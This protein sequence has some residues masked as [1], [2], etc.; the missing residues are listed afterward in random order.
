LDF[1][2][3]LDYNTKIFELSNY[4]QK[5]K[6]ALLNIMPFFRLPARAL[7]DD[8]IPDQCFRGNN[9]SIFNVQGESLSTFKNSVPGLT[10]KYKKLMSGQRNTRILKL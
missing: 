3:I 9:R 2:T 6:N 1:E 8:A 4:T 10:E 5:I 7:R